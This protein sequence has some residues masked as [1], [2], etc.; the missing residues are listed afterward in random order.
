MKQNFTI[1]KKAIEVFHSYGINLTGTQKEADF[2]GQL[3]MDPIFVN[4]L[5]FEL[6]YQLQVI[7]QDEKLGEVH[8]PKDLILLLLSIPQEN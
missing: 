4:G 2:V 8:T 3:Q 1:L 5:I 7:F 6:E